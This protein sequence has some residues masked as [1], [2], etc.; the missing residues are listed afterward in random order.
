VSERPKA[1]ALLGG[2]VIGGGWAAR[3]VLNGIDVRVYDP[4]PNAPRRISAILENARRAYGRLT[5]APLPAE[6][7]LRYAESVEEAV[8]GADFIQ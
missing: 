5:L 4:D 3:L 1:A 8:A 2:G 7:S 6:G